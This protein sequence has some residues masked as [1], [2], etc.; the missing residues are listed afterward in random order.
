[1]V[2]LEHE[3]LFTQVH[4][5]AVTC[6]DVHICPSRRFCLVLCTKRFSS[7]YLIKQFHS[8]ISQVFILICSNSLLY[9]PLGRKMKEKNLMMDNMEKA[10]VFHT[11]SW[12]LFF[13]FFSLSQY[14][15]VVL[16]LVP[17]PRPLC[18]P[19][20]LGEDLGDPTFGKQQI[21]I[22]LENLDV[23]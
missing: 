21:R 1:M 3:E 18:V 6:V 14:S 23:Q 7:T 10:A 9:L 19:A 13:F 16:T 12:F 2:S 8:I 20:W 11:F 17:S 4:T 22:Y 15:Q 5:C